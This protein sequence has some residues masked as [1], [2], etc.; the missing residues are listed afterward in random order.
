[1]RMLLMSMQ[2]SDL[3]SGVY[4]DI[5]GVLPT[6]TTTERFESLDLK[7]LFSVFKVKKEVLIVALACFH[8]L[9]TSVQ[10]H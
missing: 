2:G 4:I 7:R 5:T 10:M 3:F 6:E 9:Q 1:M 8:P